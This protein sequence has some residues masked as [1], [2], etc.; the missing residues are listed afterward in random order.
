MLTLEENAWVRNILERESRELLS[1]RM[2]GLAEYSCFLESVPQFLDK[3][4]EC[5]SLSEVW[6]IQVLKSMWWKDVCYSIWRC[7][8][9]YKFVYAVGFCLRCSDEVYV[10]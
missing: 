1:D 2:N 9:V 3:V 8:V 6:T 7:D 4:D 10:D 5:S